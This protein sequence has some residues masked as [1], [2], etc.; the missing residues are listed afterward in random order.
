MA[1]GGFADKS[2]IVS[3]NKIYTFDEFFSGILKKFSQLIIKM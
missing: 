3:K 2:F 1:L